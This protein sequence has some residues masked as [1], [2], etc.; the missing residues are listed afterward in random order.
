VSTSE[1]G[2][3]TVE[4]ILNLYARFGA[5]H[6]G[7]DV[8]QVEHALQCA[9]HARRDAAN[10]VLVVAALLHDVGHLVAPARGPA[11]RDDVDDDHHEALGAQ[12]L[13]R[14]FGP[15]VA[16]PVALH[17]TAKRWR[18]TVDPDYHEG[19]SAASTASLLAQ[20]G[21]L[22]PSDRARFEAHPSFGPAVALRGWDD[23]A[24]DPSVECGAMEDYRP[25]LVRLAARQHPPRD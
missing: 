11:W 17:V 2:P 24:K 12:A 3:P 16:A 19:L 23:E 4:S 25:L 10:E 6:Y 8:T 9:A 22:A 21:L 13:T 5:D 1:V 15:D 7:E 20:G 14:L 18:C